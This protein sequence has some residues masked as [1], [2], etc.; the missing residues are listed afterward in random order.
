MKKF[1]IKGADVLLYIGD[2]LV[3]GQ[4][5]IT[6]DITADS[7]DTTSKDNDGWKTYLAGLREW[8]ATL[9]A[10]ELAG[11]EGKQQ[12]QLM[13]SILGGET[14]EAKIVV[15]GK[16][17]MSG[18]AALTSKS[19]SGDYS[20]VSLGSYELK[21][22]DAPDISYVPFIDTM[23]ISGTSVTLR[24]TEAGTAVVGEKTL[25]D[26]IVIEGG[27]S[28]ITISSATLSTANNVATITITASAALTS[29]TKYKATIAAGTLK[30]GDA[31]QANPISEEATAA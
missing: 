8:G 16:F 22:A 13:K 31:V 20:D 1:P 2:K 24:L 29:G 25:K 6:V 19:T 5:N 23:T 3:A 15:P 18:A 28:A 7:I 30:N 14:V 12:V 21:G 27:E 26:C 10:I 4:R 11:N 17:V 9:D